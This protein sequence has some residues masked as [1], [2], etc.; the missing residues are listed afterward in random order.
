[1]ESCGPLLFKLCGD[2]HTSELFFVFQNANKT[3]S[4][5]RAMQEAFGRYWSNLAKFGTPNGIANASSL[6][7]HWPRYDRSADQHL[8]LKEPGL[9]AGSGL[10]Q[11]T[12][13]VLDQLGQF[14]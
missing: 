1:M 5:D 2:F 7:L 3:I 13:D 14:D 10:R 6:P 9:A 4:D 11:D 12:C 8:I